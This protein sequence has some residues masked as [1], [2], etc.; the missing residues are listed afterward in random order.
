MKNLVGKRSS[1]TTLLWKNMA[2]RE[3]IIIQKSRLNWIR[4]GDINNRLL[5][6]IVKGRLM[7]VIRKHF[8]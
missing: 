5:N 2:T 1:A 6:C 8:M 3:R 7:E 4:D